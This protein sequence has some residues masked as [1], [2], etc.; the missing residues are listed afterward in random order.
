MEF[1]QKPDTLTFAATMPNFIVDGVYNGATVTLLKGNDTLLSEDMFSSGQRLEI[2]VKDVINNSL[3]IEIPTLPIYYQKEAMDIFT[4]KIKCGSDTLEYS[5]NAIRGGYERIKI[6]SRYDAMRVLYTFQPATKIITTE[7]PE[8]LTFF[9]NL[10]YLR[11]RF[12]FYLPH[13]DLTATAYID[14]IL[15]STDSTGLYVIDC[16]YSHAYELAIPAGGYGF[17]Y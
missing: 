4:L 9:V 17:A 11:V 8:W 16:S 3:S 13:G 12:R 7:S 2:D 6:P 15:Y 1:I 14:N 5:F 10:E